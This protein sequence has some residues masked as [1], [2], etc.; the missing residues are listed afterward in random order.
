[1]AVTYS[2]LRAVR[3]FKANGIYKVGLTSLESKKVKLLVYA[4]GQDFEEKIPVLMSSEGVIHDG[5]VVISL[6][7]DT[8][9]MVDITLQRESLGSYRVYAEDVV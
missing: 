4:I 8:R 6:T 9:L 5:G 2:D 7:K 3:I 1:M